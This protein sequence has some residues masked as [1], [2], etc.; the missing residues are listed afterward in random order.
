LLKLYI[1]TLDVD[2][3]NLEKSHNGGKNRKEEIK[4]E[5]TPENGEKRKEKKAVES[6]I[7]TLSRSKGGET[8]YFKGKVFL[9][10]GPFDS[11]ER[12]SLVG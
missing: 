3:E 9:F 10:Y 12:R 6:P 7:K 1:P 8:T 4:Q 11:E 5:E 2:E